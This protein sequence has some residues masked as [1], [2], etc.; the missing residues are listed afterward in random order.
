[1]CASG[2]WIGM[3]GCRMAQTPRVER[4]LRLI[5]TVN[6]GAVASV[7]RNHGVLPRNG[8]DLMLIIG[9]VIVNQYCSVLDSAF[10]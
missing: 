1:M 4:L 8:E 6:G 10:V 5:P 2:V 9:R 3:V 7:T